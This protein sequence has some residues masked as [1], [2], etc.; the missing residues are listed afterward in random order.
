M[1]VPAGKPGAWGWAGRL[2]VSCVVPDVGH[3]GGLLLQVS[4]DSVLVFE[5]RC[6][7]P[8]CACDGV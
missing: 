3:G 2:G 1:T 8:S 6:T 4:G 5:R 7:K